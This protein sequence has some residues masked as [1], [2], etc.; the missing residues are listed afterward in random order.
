[1]S[2]F[3]LRFRQPPP[4]ALQVDGTPVTTATVGVPY[5]GFLL[6]ATGGSE[7]YTWSVQG[8][9]IPG[10]ELSGSGNSRLYSGTP[11]TAGDY[12]NRKI[13]VTDSTSAF[14]ETDPFSISVA[15][16][17]EVVDVTVGP[18]TFQFAP[19]SATQGTYAVSNLATYDDG[20]LHKWVSGTLDLVATDPPY[21]LI[22]GTKYNSSGGVEPYTDRR[23]NGLQ[24]NPGN[25][26]DVAYLAGLGF[27]VTAS[28]NVYGRAIGHG[29]DSLQPV[30]GGALFKD[31]LNFDPA[32]VGTLTGLTDVTLA[33]SISYVTAPMPYQDRDLLTDIALLTIVSESPPAGAFRPGQAA[34]DKASNWTTADVDTAKL[35]A[36]PNLAVPVGETAPSYAS[37][38]AQLVKPW[39]YAVTDNTG[40]ARAINAINN[41]PDYGQDIGWIVGNALLL[42]CTNTLTADQK[43][44]MTYALIQQGE[45]LRARVTGGNLGEWYGLGGGNSWPL[46]IAAFTCWM[47]EGAP[48]V[49]AFQALLDQAT[50]DSRWTEY[51]QLFEI[52]G[53]YTRITPE[54]FSEGRPLLQYRHYMVGEVDWRQ[55]AYDPTGCGYNFD[56]AYRGIVSSYVFGIV[57]ALRL[58]GALDVLNAPKLTT[59]YDR[60]RDWIRVETGS[61][62][63][64]PTWHVAMY[65]NYR[66]AIYDGAPAR[67]A[68]YANGAYVWVHADDLFSETSIPA[69]SDFVV[70]VNGSPVTKTGVDIYGR[71]A[72]VILTAPLVGGET[73]SLSYTKGAN[74]L[75]NLDGDEL[76]A[77]SATAVTNQTN[78]PP[79]GF[80]TAAMLNTSSGAYS[81]LDYPITDKETV[82]WG[83]L[84]VK[85]RIASVAGSFPKTIVGTQQTNK[86]RLALVSATTM[87]FVIFSNSVIRFKP[88]ASQFNPSNN[89]N[90]DLTVWFSFDLSKPA[91]TDGMKMT[92]NGS[93][94]ATSAFDWNPASTALPGGFLDL[95]ATILSPIGYMA[96][97]DGSNK[98]N[99]GWE[100]VCAAFGSDPA[101]MPNI[102]DAGFIAASAGDWGGNAQNLFPSPPDWFHCGTLAEA[103][104]AYGAPNRGDIVDLPARPVGAY[105]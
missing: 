63:P 86:F 58:I 89:L 31:E 51:S 44:D 4:L 67:Q 7:P 94:I 16:G 15:A 71:N 23:S 11:T 97:G 57:T 5:A 88:T 75:K 20:D 22:D 21:A 101:D 34:T 96:A 68:I 47:M 25:I 2:N 60:Y 33:K 6:T 39:Q 46:G 76:A 73:V 12:T 36:L 48:G 100:R 10:I 77:F 104:S 18:T 105:T 54:P 27:A 81:V 91:A 32:H 14:V 42:L 59:Y 3:R 64:I 61:T 93:S 79:A 95:A 52:G 78:A 66:G 82:K 98:V 9:A 45:D 62:N 41:Q 24:K 85:F 84:G 17:G 56:T 26:S 92:I 90:T 30:G 49:D 102:L 74:P 1:M 80:T 35:A 70:S 87:Q 103:N 19:A 99:G 29:F 69:T 65:D 37:V 40:G 72:A 53:R 55:T 28:D 8:G 38:M 83:V 43:R 50:N 13:R